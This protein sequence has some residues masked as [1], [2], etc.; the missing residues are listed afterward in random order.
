MRQP[1]LDEATNLARRLGEPELARILERLDLPENYE[2]Q[3]ERYHAATA[4]ARA[5]ELLDDIR[6]RAERA[7][8]GKAGEQAKQVVERWAR[9]SGVTVDTFRKQATAAQLGRLHDVLSRLPRSAPIPRRPES[10]DRGRA[11]R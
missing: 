7:F 1:E 3:T 2:Q 9:E 6:A 4:E 8:E 5:R 11:A 10:N